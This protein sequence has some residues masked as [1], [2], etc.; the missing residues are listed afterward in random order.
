M[1][2]LKQNHLIFRR[3]MVPISKHWYYSHKSETNWTPKKNLSPKNCILKPRNRKSYDLNLNIYAFDLL[4]SR[5]FHKHHGYRF[6]W[7]ESEYTKPST[8]RKFLA[9]LLD[10]QCI[11]GKY[12]LLHKMITSQGIAPTKGASGESATSITQT[13]IE[14][15]LRV[16]CGGENLRNTVIV[17]PWVVCPW[18]FMAVHW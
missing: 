14:P 9:R 8:F 15:V 10:V 6:T 17:T 1:Y 18:L 3:Q 12:L 4:L 11:S 13:G 5:I 7:G 16:P 2:K